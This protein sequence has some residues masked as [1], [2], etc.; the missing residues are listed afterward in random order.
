[1]AA[2]ADIPETTPNPVI[3]ATKTLL[4]LHTPLPVRSTKIIECPRHTLSA[5]VILPA[6]GNAFTVTV[7]VAVA[8]PH[9]LVTMYLI[10]SAPAVT[11]VTKPPLETVARALL[12]LQAP[13]VATSVNNIAV[14]THTFEGPVI[15][16]AFG[17]ILTVI[18][19]V[20]VV[21]P[22]ELVTAYLIVSRPAVIPVTTPPETVALVLLL[23]HVP[24][25]TTSVNMMA[26]P[27]HTPEAPVIL[28]AFG[29][30]LT[31]TVLTAMQPV[32]KV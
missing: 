2:P 7:F 1:V 17:N 14:P 9:A 15:L 26:E 8:V 4:L 5:P 30:G 25:V 27:T 13:P 12:L 28:P 3:V 18:A 11:P 32:G 20:A 23:L 6:F 19:F 31:V 21:V 22:H 24:P 10:V 16:P 29:N